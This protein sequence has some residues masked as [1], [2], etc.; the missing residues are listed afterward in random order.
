G[1]RPR[2]PHQEPVDRPLPPVSQQRPLEWLLER[3]AKLVVCRAAQIDRDQVDLLNRSPRDDAETLNKN[4][5]LAS[6]K[7]RPTRFEERIVVISKAE[8]AER[9]AKQEHIVEGDGGGGK[10]GT[11]QCHDIDRELYLVTLI[12]QRIAIER[13]LA[14]WRRGLRVRG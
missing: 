8:G 12:G 6:P 2:Q 10:S 9:Q 11:D 4:S 3:D 1:H 13:V 7:P 14:H 5:V